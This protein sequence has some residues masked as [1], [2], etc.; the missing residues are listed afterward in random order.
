MTAVIA[1]LRMRAVAR[2]RPLLVAATAVALLVVLTA[3]ACG[4]DDGQGSDAAVPPD[5]GTT[6]AADD[7][8]TS[9]PGSRAQVTFVELGSDSCIPCKEMRPIMAEIEKKYSGSV[10]VVFYDVYE[11][12]DKAEEFGIRVIPTQVFLDESGNEFYRHEGFLTL[13]AIESLLAE[14]GIEPMRGQ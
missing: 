14:R 11:Q 9:S 5:A 8:Q 4:G 2:S 12:G 6:T 7:G 10:E 3:S 1:A 13:M